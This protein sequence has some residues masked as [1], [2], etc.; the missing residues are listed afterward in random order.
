MT[1]NN[2]R[3]SFLGAKMKG[4]LEILS[5]IQQDYISSA[6]VSRVEYNSIGKGET[7]FFDIESISERYEEIK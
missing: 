4:N 2:S 7:Q 1:K 6:A 3:L 5:P